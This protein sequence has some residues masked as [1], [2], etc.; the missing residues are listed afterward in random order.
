MHKE[1]NQVD[2]PP[3]D[4][5]VWRY[6]DFTKFVSLL[7][8]SALF[9]ARADKLGDLFE[10]Y[11][12]ISGILRQIPASDPESVAKVLR[13]PI[14]FTL[15]SYW[16]EGPYESEAMW[17]L[18]SSETSGIAIRTNF[19]SLLDSLKGNPGLI[20]GRVNYI[21]Y[22]EI[23]LPSIGDRWLQFLQKRKSFE[24]E[25]EVRII[26]QDFPPEFPLNSTPVHDTGK[27]YEVDLSILIHEV[28]VAPL[29]PC[30]LVELV[31][32]VAARYDLTAPVVQ[33]TL[34]APPNWD[35]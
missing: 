8:K 16:H 21:D 33:S 6:M 9:F 23:G 32:S 34:A 19:G 14:P 31:Q 28:I 25:R 11:W 24:H 26:I 10:G 1:H 18:Y 35:S 27:Y 13:L 20:L 5:I 3:D 4:L 29:G 30:W 2:I 15:I 17:K 7:D 12:P 22:D